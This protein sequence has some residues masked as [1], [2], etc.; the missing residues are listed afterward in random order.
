MCITPVWYSTG[1][2]TADRLKMQD[3]KIVNSSKYSLSCCTYVFHR[4]TFVLA[5]SVLA[6][7]TFA[8]SYLRIPYLHIPSSGTCVFRTCVFSR[9]G[10]TTYKA[11]SN[12]LLTSYSSCF[13]FT[14]HP[15]QLKTVT[16]NDMFSKCV[17]F[18][19]GHLNKRA[20]VW[21]PW[22]PPGS[23]TDFRE[24]ALCRL[25]RHTFARCCRC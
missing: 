6:F 2:L 10:R 25:Y 9:P 20:G 1:E 8:C 24:P 3:W 23:A 12:P 22:T 14:K 18:K 17:L 19:K 16:T 11:M 15:V 4:C 5:F 13:V 21:T 7:S